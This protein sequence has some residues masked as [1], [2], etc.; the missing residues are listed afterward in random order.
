MSAID[1][2]ISTTAGNW[3]FDGHPEQMTDLERAAWLTLVALCG[4]ASAAEES[5]TPRRL[6][7]ASG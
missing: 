5:D 1:L 7:K 6:R 2:T 3:H 4:A